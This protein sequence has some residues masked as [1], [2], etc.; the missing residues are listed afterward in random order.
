M[1]NLQEEY[2]TMEVLFLIGAV[3]AFF[4][5]LV[6][7]VKRPRNSPDKLLIGWM[8]FMGLHL[9][10]VYLGASGFYRQHPDWFGYDASF[11]LVQGPLL[12]AYIQLATRP[13]ARVSAVWLLHLV[14]FVFFTI[15]L[16]RMLQMPDVPD[17]Y[18]YI[19][20]VMADPNNL[21]LQIFG[22]FLHLHLIAYLVTSVWALRRFAKKLPEEFSYSEGIDLS[23]LR[24]IVLGLAMVSLLILVGLLLNDVL[25]FV[26]HDFKAYM[27]Y[28]AF[29]LVPFYLMFQ[30][31]RQGIVYPY[32][33][34]EEHQARYVSS[35]LEKTTSQELASQLSEKMTTEKPYLNGKLT[36]AHLAGQLNIHPKLLS[37]VINEN[38]K[39][40]FFNYINQHRVEEVKRRIM[41][42]KYHH[43]TLLGIALDCGFN[44]KSSFNSIFKKFT[45][46]TPQAF[47]ASQD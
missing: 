30:A 2:F 27:I 26:S 32:S 42:G 22:L 38:F 14:P 40:N 1:V 34:E 19:A 24:A 39:Q 13:D 36:L 17:R 43:L 18:T 45:G 29:A 10:G 20:S 15:A 33:A 9:V 16:T 6:L 11:L 31:I 7:A 4:L 28:S 21:L 46:T 3:Q 37:Q 5:A 25:A 12:W 35:S 23:W 8:A 44:T 47:K 41:S